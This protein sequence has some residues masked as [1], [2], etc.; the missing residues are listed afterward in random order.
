MSISGQ[1]LFLSG[2]NYREVDGGAV[3]HADFI[4]NLHHAAEGLVKMIFATKERLVT[5]R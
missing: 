5:V 1:R 4:I 2:D 3:C